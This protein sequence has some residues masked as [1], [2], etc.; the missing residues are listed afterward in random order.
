M[1]WSS[2]KSLSAGSKVYC[3]EGETVTS[4]QGTIS[5]KQNN[6]YDK[7]NNQWADI[8]YV[9]LTSLDKD[10]SCLNISNKEY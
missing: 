3:R 10:L 2:Y 5:T 1:A 6:I 7:Y 4:G 9:S 8:N